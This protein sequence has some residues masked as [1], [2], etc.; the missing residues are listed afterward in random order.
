MIFNEMSSTI[1]IFLRLPKTFQN[2]IFQFSL[3]YRNSKNFVLG[4]PEKMTCELALDLLQ[5][6]SLDGLV[7]RFE[8][9]NFKV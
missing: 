8:Q 1:Q 4:S 5:L 9:F 3:G 6:R 7:K 2:Q